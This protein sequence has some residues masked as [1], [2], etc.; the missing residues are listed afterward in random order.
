M[1]SQKVSVAMCTFNGEAYLVEQIES[2]L[3]QTYSNIELVICDDGSSDGTLS[4]LEDYA[5]KDP[6]ITLILNTENLGFL[7]NFE[8]AL[9]FALE[10]ILP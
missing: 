3:D 5:V 2:I 9:A 10:N 8:K 7:K 6:R 1:N 4:I